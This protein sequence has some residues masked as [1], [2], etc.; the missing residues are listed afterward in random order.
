MV[1]LLV[2]FLLLVPFVLKTIDLRL[3]LFP[4]AIFPSSATQFNIKDDTEF[5][6]TELYGLRQNTDELV[7]L[8]NRYFFKDIQ[9][10]YFPLLAKQK[11]GLEYYEKMKTKTNKLNIDYLVHSK[12]SKEEIKQTKKWLRSALLQQGCKDSIILVVRKKLVIDKITRNLVS[13][14]NIHEESII[15]N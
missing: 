9:V 1:S 7:K 13:N 11:F 14:T 8:N 10:H 2:G 15:V 3:E 5:N 12:V 6:I 4:S